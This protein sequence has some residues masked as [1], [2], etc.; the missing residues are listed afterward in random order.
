MTNQ[1]PE[2]NRQ[3]AAQP[4]APAETRPSKT[5]RNSRISGF[6]NLDRTERLNL[7]RDRGF[8]DEESYEYLSETDSGLGFETADKMIE[9]A[10]GTFELPMGLGLN[11]TVNGRDYVVP[12]AIEEPSV[13]AAVS[14]TAKIVRGAGGFESKCKSSLM[15][16]QIQVLEC[17]DLD[18]A[19]TSVLEERQRIIHMANELHPKMVERG[20][21]AKDLEVRVL[22]NSGGN[23]MLVVHLLV[24]VCDAM[25]AN[26]VNT[27]AEGVAPFIEELTGGRVSLRILSNLADR[28][29]VHSQCKIP[30]D[31]LDWKGFPGEEV[32]RGIAE[33]SEF[34]E[35]DP[36][37]AAT[38]NKGVMNGISSVCIASGNDWRALEA[39]AHAYCCQD[40][41]YRPMATWH[42]E[43][44]ED[45][46][47]YLVGQLTI[48]VQLGTV[49]G[50]TKLHPTVKVAHRILDIDSAAQL[51]EVMGAVGLAQNLAALKALATEGIQSGH[52]SLHARS[53]A[54]TAGATD[55]EM[56]E[57]VERLI[58]TEDIKVRT[59]QKI[60]AEMRS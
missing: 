29:L 18:E 43:E 36:Y 41:Q 13:V 30:F 9:N 24:D 45:G 46:Q 10:I 26:L 59:A 40:G 31:R 55:E 8:L 19:R 44:D 6:Y 28:R 22:E 14:H 12:M 56:D 25:G 17:E 3:D 1:A 53:V 51:G 16:G 23:D 21:G 38:H 32:A 52:M 50:P 54:A 60:L 58:E 37:R 48:P 5:E 27:M 11:F 57:L 42:L 35:L 2:R 47:G 7:L 49:G 39:G 20:G 4:S 33:A 34:A 15:I